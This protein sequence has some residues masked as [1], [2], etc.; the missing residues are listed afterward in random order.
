[1]AAGWM[2][3]RG[4][5]QKGMQWLDRAA[6]VLFIGFGLKLAFTDAPVVRAGH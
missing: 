2:A 3:R 6:S 5:V 4:A 1:V